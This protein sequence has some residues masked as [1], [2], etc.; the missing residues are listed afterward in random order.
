MQV[1]PAVMVPQFME[2]RSVVHE[3]SEYKPIFADVDTAPLEDTGGDVVMAAKVVSDKANPIIT[4]ATTAVVIGSFRFAVIIPHTNTSYIVS[5]NKCYCV[6]EQHK[7]TSTIQSKNAKTRTIHIEDLWAF[8]LTFVKKE[9]KLFWL[10]FLGT[11]KH[12]YYFLNS[13]NSICNPF[14]KST[15][16]LK[17]KFS[18]ALAGSP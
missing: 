17:P 13:S 3:L 15:M 18:A 9:E 7:Y 8:L 12:K 16:A 11:G 4:N 2:V 14:V 10:S 5:L 6:L 1:R